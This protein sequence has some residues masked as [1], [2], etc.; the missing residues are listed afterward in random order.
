MATSSS[1]KNIAASRTLQVARTAGGGL[2]VLD[3]FESGDSTAPGYPVFSWNQPIKIVSMSPQGNPLIVLDGATVNQE[4]VGDPRNWTAKTGS[5]SQWF[6]YAAGQSSDEKRY[7]LT[8]AYPAIWKSFWWRVPE[9]YTHPGTEITANQK[10]FVMWQDA[11]EGLGD[12]SSCGM[13]L[14][15]EPDGGSYL[16]CKISAGGFTGFGPDLAKYRNFIQ[17][18]QD[19]GRWM[20]IVVNLA[21]ETSL[22]ASD[23]VFKVWRKWQNESSYTLTHN[24]VG[25]A[26]KKGPASALGFKNGYL[27]GWANV[28]YAAQTDFLLDDFTLS[29]NSLL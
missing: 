3:G 16:Y 27:M 10:F 6:K 24:L 20:K 8:Q 1:P 2:I 14:R 5:N 15:K 4:L 12:G 28:A 29:T 23:G 18:P 13:E 17:I 21:T 11:Y 26:I 22:G 19:Q 9:N 25:Q 7:A